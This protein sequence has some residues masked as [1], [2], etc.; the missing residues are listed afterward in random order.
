M[1]I[2]VID[3]LFLVFIVLMVIHGYVKGFIE[4][5]FS[6]AG[7]V[8]GI[9]AAVLLYHHGAAFIR[10]KVMQ[11]VRYVPEILSFAAI[12]IIVMVILKMLE[13][14]LKDVMKN[15]K[16]LGG[17][18]KILGLIFGLVEG[19][20]L[21]ALVIFVLSIQPI[22]DVSK[23]LSDSTFAQILLPLIR[24]PL[25]RG[26]DAVNAA[27]LLLPGMRFPWFPV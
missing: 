24:I 4:E 21:T 16:V 5:L 10:T 17:V 15:A 1:N 2:P 26:K 8:L 19:V 3:L 11:N 23:I 13:Y 18:N 12:F 14:I 22:F 6:W 7:L 20:T 27:F 9:W 25:H